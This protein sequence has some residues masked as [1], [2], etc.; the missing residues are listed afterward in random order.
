VGSK[1]PDGPIRL[2][3]LG[4]GPSRTDVRSGEVFSD[5][6]GKIVEDAL[7]FIGIEDG[8]VYANALL[9][10]PGTGD[11]KRGVVTAATA[12]CKPRLD[13]LLS[14]FD[15][16][17][18]I[19]ALGSAVWKLLGITPYRIDGYRGHPVVGAEHP[20]NFLTRPGEAYKFKRLVEKVMSYNNIQTYPR[21]LVYET[22][23]VEV[24]T[25][26]PWNW[27]NDLHEDDK[28]TMD[29]ETSSTDWETADLLQVGFAKPSVPGEDP[30]VCGTDTL[31]IKGNLLG[32]EDVRAWFMMAEKATRER[33]GGH[34]FKFDALG[35]NR[36]LYNV[37]FNTTWDTML[38]AADIHFYW[39][40]GLKDLA[41]FYFDAID[42]PGRYIRP[43]L[44]KLPQKDK[45]YANVPY[46]ELGRYLTYDVHYTLLL[47]Y[48]L[49]DELFVAKRLTMPNIQFTTPVAN[50][51]TKTESRG[52][53]VDLPYLH[54]VEKLMSSAQFDKREYISKITGGLVEN[55]NSHKQVQDYCWNVLNLP[56]PRGIMRRTER[57]VGAAELDYWEDALDEPI[58]FLDELREA[59]RI[60]KMLTSYVRP[61][62]KYAVPQGDG[63]YR[64][65]TKF[66]QLGTVS[67]RISAENPPMQTIPR[68]G[69][70]KDRAGW[71]DYIKRGF[72][73]TPGYRLITADYSQA[74][75]RVLA[76]LAGDEG[77][78]NAYINGE[79]IHYYVANACFPGEEKKYRPP[80]KNFNFAFVYARTVDGAMTAV[81]GLT[82]S[83]KVKAAEAVSTK[84]SRLVD[85]K[86]ENFQRVLTDGYIDLPYFNRRV[87]WDLVTKRLMNTVEKEAT[88]YVIQGTA[89]LL[90]LQAM[91][92]VRPK[93]EEMGGHLL[94][95]IHDSIFAEVPIDKAIDGAHMLAGGM[96]ETGNRIFPTVPW[97][98]EAEVGDNWADLKEV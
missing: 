11:T 65:F 69:D 20:Q 29:I 67:G 15:Q 52:F 16:H 27:F 59:R 78:L 76:M 81:K 7:K 48:Q 82:Q 25:Q 6:V 50:M 4:D 57:S 42:W 3:V 1:I 2:I 55:P 41:A 35:V 87:Q 28:V 19:L 36:P 70:P 17:V 89:G 31:I 45:T 85:Y 5:D 24:S 97:V 40:K 72:I 38:M 32:M 53:C 46:D 96:V 84:F 60:S 64:V 61:I 98:A 49:E 47:A 10:H 21:P 86:K 43:H 66:K 54:D 37:L 13:I 56:K 92:D 73:A 91:V 22:T 94:N 51:L 90:C 12:A 44:D 34:N 93:I 77:F 30:R 18:P 58:E 71:S 75:L 63:T 33:M 39:F 79:D 9:C 80:I 74:E 14:Q 95:Q 26:L 88:N 68:K 23:Y 83:E 8:V 62:I